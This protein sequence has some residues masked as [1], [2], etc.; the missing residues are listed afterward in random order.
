M[1]LQGAVGE[2]EAAIGRSSVAGSLS[3]K[4]RADDRICWWTISQTG[5][6]NAWSVRKSLFTD[7]QA[8]KAGAFNAELPITYPAGRQLIMMFGT[9]VSGNSR[10]ARASNV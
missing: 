1:S 7:P 8:S 9:F 4:I 3:G 6:V 2:M 5:L 10:P